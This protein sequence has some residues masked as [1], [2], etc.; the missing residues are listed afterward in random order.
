MCSCA[1]IFEVVLLVVCV[2]TDTV[3]SMCLCSI[4]YGHV[5]V[6]KCLIYLCYS[7][8][9]RTQHIHTAKP[10]VQIAPFRETVRRSTAPARVIA[11]L[12][13][14]SKRSHTHTH[15]RG[16]AHYMMAARLLQAAELRGTPV[17]FVN[18]DIRN[19]CAHS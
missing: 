16:N 5:I 3:R 11:H 8:D 13:P 15:I 19:L 18:I 2:Y 1:R 9:A 4:M 6:I 17:K 12:L 10:H 14:R 7:A